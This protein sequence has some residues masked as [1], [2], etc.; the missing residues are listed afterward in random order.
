[1]PY[2]STQWSALVERTCVTVGHMTAAS[3]LQGGP[4][5]AFLAESVADYIRH[6]L[7]GVAT[8]IEDIPCCTNHPIV[9]VL[10]I[11]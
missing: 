3:I 1:M 11:S 4:A 5:P 2:S 10:H 7:E 6:G 8:H 9:K